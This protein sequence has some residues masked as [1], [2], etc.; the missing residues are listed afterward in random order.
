MKS[1]TKQR[2][3]FI[4]IA[5]IALVILV[6][7][8]FYM[9]AQPS[10]VEIVSDNDF[11]F[12]IE[13]PEV[14]INL[15]NAKY[16][17]SGQIKINYDNESIEIIENNT[18]EGVSVSVIGDS[19]SYDLSKDY[20]NNPKTTIATLKLDVIKQNVVNFEVDENSYLNIK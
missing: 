3:V 4:L 12:E 1:S 5:V 7:G 17:D 18:A 15:S 10:K 11:Y 16:A 14:R 6:G 8:W 2:N 13:E 20:F 9:N 19:I